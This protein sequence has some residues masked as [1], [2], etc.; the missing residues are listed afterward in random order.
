MNDANPKRVFWELSPKLPDNCIITA[1]SGSSA[2]WFARDLKIRRGMM[3]SLSGNLATMG[4]GVP[5]TIAAKFAFPDRVAIACVG[6]GAMLMNGINGLITIAKY[7]KEWSDPRLIVL[8]L[9]NLDLN[10][11][12]WEQ[13]VMMGDPKFD[14]SQDVPAFPFASYAQM[15]GL[16]GINVEKPEQIAD[17]WDQAFAANRPVVIEAHTDPE[18][19]TL[20]PHITFDM[21]VKFSESLLRDSDAP[22]MIRGAFKDAVENFLPHKK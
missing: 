7:W 16:I 15:L 8:V 6:D 19:P 20:P 22:G 12:T 3:A 17:A 11:V 13:R 21:A 2:N 18:V 4:P 5:Y 9:A 14:A 1:D 10:Q